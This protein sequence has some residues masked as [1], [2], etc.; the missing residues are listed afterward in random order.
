[1]MEVKSELNF[2]NNLPEFGRYYYQIPT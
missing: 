2:T 1:M